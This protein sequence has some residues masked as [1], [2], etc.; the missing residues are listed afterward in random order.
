MQRT[1]GKCFAGT[2]KF[3]QVFKDQPCFFVLVPRG[4]GDQSFSDPKIL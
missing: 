1:S 3:G 2:E 4:T